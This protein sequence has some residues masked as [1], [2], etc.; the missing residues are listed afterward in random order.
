MDNTLDIN[1]FN[2]TTAN[3]PYTKFLG[4]VVDDTLNWNNTY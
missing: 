4:L 2:K 3:R 1:Y